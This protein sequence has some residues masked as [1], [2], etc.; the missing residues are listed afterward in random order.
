MAKKKVLFPGGF[1]GETLGAKRQVI[2][3]SKHKM[4]VGSS[5]A[6]HFPIQLH[7]N[8]CCCCSRFADFSLP[9]TSVTCFWHS[10]KLGGGATGVLKVKYVDIIR[11]T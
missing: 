4:K 5:M 2:N 10:S 8:S 6:H 7:N 3:V 9:V 1:E 11:V